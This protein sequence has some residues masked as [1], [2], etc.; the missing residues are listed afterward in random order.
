MNLYHMKNVSYIH[1]KMCIGKFKVFLFIIAP[2]WKQASKGKMDNQTG[3][4]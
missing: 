4:Y 2:K 3:A 1:K